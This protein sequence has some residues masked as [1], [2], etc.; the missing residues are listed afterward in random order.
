MGLGYREV[1]EDDRSLAFFK[2][3]KVLMNAVYILMIVMAIFYVSYLIAVHFYSLSFS[4]GLI[5]LLAGH[6]AGVGG[7]FVY[8]LSGILRGKEDF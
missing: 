4:T 1:N 6:L 3:R 7:F 2:E 5:I 8:I